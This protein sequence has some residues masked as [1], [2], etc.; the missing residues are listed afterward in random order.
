MVYSARV[1]MWLVVYGDEMTG[2]GPVGDTRAWN[3]VSRFQSDR[4]RLGVS[5]ER[6]I[7]NT[8]RSEKRYGK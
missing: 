2:F 8:A 7:D 6:R 5:N 3:D 4:P 1:V